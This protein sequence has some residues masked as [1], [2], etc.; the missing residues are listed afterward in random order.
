MNPHELV[1][2]SMHQIGGPVAR[3]ADQLTPVP[4][5]ARV[6]QSI[7]PWPARPGL[8]CVQSRC[9]SPSGITAKRDFS[10]RR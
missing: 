5:R 6:G 10:L 8:P 2:T 4:L 7:S 3:Q 9:R 1:I